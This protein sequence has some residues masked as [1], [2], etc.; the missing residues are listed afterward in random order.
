[1]QPLW[2]WAQ[3][4]SSDRRAQQLYLQAAR[5]EPLNPE[6]WYEL[7]YFEAQILADWRAAYRHLDRSWHLNPYGPA[8]QPPGSELLDKARCKVDPSTC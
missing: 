6:T 8:G 4:E 7:G 3:S 1:V 2:L 5:R